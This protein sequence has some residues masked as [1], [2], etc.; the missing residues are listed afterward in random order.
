MADVEAILAT[1]DDTPRELRDAALLPI[2]SDT[3]RR[4]SELVALRAEHLHHNRRQSS[5]AP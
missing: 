4:E 5:P 2:A 3:P 1:L